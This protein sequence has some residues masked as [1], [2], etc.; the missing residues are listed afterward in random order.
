MPWYQTAARA[1]TSWLVIKTTAHLAI[2]WSVCLYFLPRLVIGWQSAMG[3]HALFYEPQQPLA[4]ALMAGATAIS[5]W[6][7]MLLAVKGRGTP[8][9]IDAPRRLVISGPYAW[10]RNP[11]VVCGLLQ[12]VAVSLYTGSTL[13]LILVLVAGVLWHFVRRYDEEHDLQ[14]VFGRE[15]ELYRRSVRCWMPR[16]RRWAPAQPEAAIA[17]QTLRV[18]TLGRRRSHRRH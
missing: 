11:M 12:G 18:A 16:R 5:F 1:P 8:A 7:A 15:Y 14:R 6:S 9:R 17:D 13:I 4:L 2:L 3:L 10:V